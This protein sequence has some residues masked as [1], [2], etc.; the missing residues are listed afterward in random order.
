[1]GRRPELR[2]PYRGQRTGLQVHCTFTRAHEAREP[3]ETRWPLSNGRQDYARIMRLDLRNMLPPEDPHS[4][5]RA[6]TSARKCTSRSLGAA[7]KACG[8]GTP[9]EGFKYAKACVPA[10]GFRELAGV[11]S[12]L[13]RP[14]GF[15]QEDGLLIRKLALVL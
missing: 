12:M 3:C 7:V 15:N 9:G 4:E 2:S 13:A 6:L 10:R 5:R 1:M 11:S 14:N 8:R